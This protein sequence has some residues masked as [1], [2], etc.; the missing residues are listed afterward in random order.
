MSCDC[1]TCTDSVIIVH[2]LYFSC[3][4]QY[5]WILLVFYVFGGNLVFRFRALKCST[6][7]ALEKPCCIHH[8]CWQFVNHVNGFVLIG[9]GGGCSFIDTI[10]NIKECPIYSVVWCRTL[11]KNDMIATFKEKGISQMFP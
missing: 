1:G 7:T 9:T 3:Q 6:S 8:C 2:A 5:C 10:S 11:L 4:I